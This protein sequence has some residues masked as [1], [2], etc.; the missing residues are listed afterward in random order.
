MDEVGG[1]GIVV[2]EV[3]E[4][5]MSESAKVAGVIAS[6]NQDVVSVSCIRQARFQLDGNR[7]LMF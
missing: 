3:I 7:S 4:H 5:Q 2:E 6:E 1:V